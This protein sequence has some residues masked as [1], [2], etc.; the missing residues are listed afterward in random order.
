[1]SAVN[2]ELLL[3][4]M[5][6][7]AED[8]EDFYLDEINPRSNSETAL[9][10]D[11]ETLSKDGITPPSSLPKTEKSLV[12]KL[13]KYF[14]D[15]VTLISRVLNHYLPEKYIYYRVS[16]LEGEIFEALDLLSETVPE[17][18]RLTFSGI[19]KRGFERY[20]CLN[21]AILG[22]F[23]G[24]YPELFDLRRRDARIA[25]FLYR[26][27]GELFVRKSSYERFW[28]MATGEEFFSELDS[29][30]PLTWSARK[31]MRKGDRVLMYRKAPVSAVTDIFEPQT[32]RTS[33]P[34]ADGTG[35]GL[36]LNEPLESGHTRSRR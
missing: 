20:L 36:T 10:E 17:F 34:G 4:L 11:L 31:D 19:G 27:L 32:T 12:K 2:T 14:G 8:N 7:A 9:A 22:L 6:K 35:S 29:S 26:G 25:W 13:R 21:E 28:I 30:K 16:K 5:L 1:M 18:E 23:G 24:R 15:D 3:G 33:T